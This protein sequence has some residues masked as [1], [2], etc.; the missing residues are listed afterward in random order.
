MVPPPLYQPKTFQKNLQRSQEGSE[1]QWDPN[2][3]I[4]SS[5]DARKPVDKTQDNKF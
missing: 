3:P 2:L 1:L 4:P 5:G